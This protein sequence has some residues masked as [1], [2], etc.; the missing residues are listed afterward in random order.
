MSGMPKETRAEL[1]LLLL[2]SVRWSSQETRFVFDKGLMLRRHIQQAV[3]NALVFVVSSI[4]L[5]LAC[6]TFGFAPVTQALLV[7]L[8]GLVGG[9][10]FLAT[11][12]TLAAAKFCAQ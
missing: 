1:A 3:L 6:S 2:T 10:A 11:A 5:V 9:F 4:G 12:A 7:A 8:F